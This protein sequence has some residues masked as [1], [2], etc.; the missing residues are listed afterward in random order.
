MISTI[1][2]FPTAAMLFGLFLFFLIAK[3][4]IKN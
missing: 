1:K 3:S 4:F 2:K